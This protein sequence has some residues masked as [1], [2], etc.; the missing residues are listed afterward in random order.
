M[1]FINTRPH[2]RAQPLSTALEQAAIQVFDYPLLVLTAKPLTAQLKQ[3]Y[4]QLPQIQAIVVVSPTAVE[5]GMRYLQAC[6]VE[7]STLRHVQ[8]IAVGKT[9][10]QALAHYGIDA[11]V[12]TLESSEGMLQLPLFQQD[13]QR[14]AFWRGEGG[15]QFMM[16]HCQQQGMT[17]FNFILYVRALP[18]SAQQNLPRLLQQMQQSRAVVVAISSEASWN[19]W[20]DLMQQDH[21]RLW[22]ACHY[23]VLGPRL[24]HRLISDRTNLQCDYTVTELADLSTSSIVQ[25][26]QG[27]SQFLRNV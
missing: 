19:Y 22:Q 6:K 10:A 21:L 5:I 1:L 3:H 26:I 15:R 18:M 14:I 16:Q 24:Y 20:S 25:T 7:L 8:W 11:L 17:I 23:L 2:D 12:P 4:A 9:T 13:L 27:L